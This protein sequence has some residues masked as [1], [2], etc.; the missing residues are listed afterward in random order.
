MV[1]TLQPD[2][3]PPSGVLVQVCCL[4]L[5]ATQAGQSATGHGPSIAGS[6]TKRPSGASCFTFWCVS[7][8]GRS[9]ETCSCLGHFIIHLTVRACLLADK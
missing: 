5:G 4:W 3:K 8:F 1:Q 6:L 9:T 2:E 7:H